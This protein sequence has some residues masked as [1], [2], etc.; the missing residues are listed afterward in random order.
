MSR[1]AKKQFVTKEQLWE[2][3]CQWRDSA[4]DIKDRTLSDQFALNIW[5]IAEHLTSHHR[6]VGYNQCMKED[7][8]S[9]AFHKVCLNLKNVKDEYKDSLFSYFTNTCWCA[10]MD[11]LSKH[12]K[13][14]NLK[15]KMMMEQMEAMRATNPLLNQDMIRSIQRELEQYSQPEEEED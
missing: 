12:Y 11:Y 6:F 5:K 13:Q 3:Y 2:G 9:D 15:K 7:M 1:K 14:Q 10:F 4:V 8:I